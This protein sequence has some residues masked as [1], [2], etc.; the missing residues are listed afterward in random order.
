MT[1]FIRT[2]LILPLLISA[3]S[4]LAQQ[5]PPPFELNVSPKQ[6]TTLNQGEMCYLELD[7]TWQLAQKQTVCL[8]ANELQLEC[9]QNQ[10]R[11]QLKKSLS[12]HND[13]IISLQNKDRQVLQTHTIRYAWVHKKNNNKAMRWRMF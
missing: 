7:V 9:W 3:P 12:V 11:G 5:N 6:C 2:S 4:S 1:L 10:T 8:Y 13:L